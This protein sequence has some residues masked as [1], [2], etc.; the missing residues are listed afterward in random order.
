[1]CVRVCVCVYM[2]K[3]F[4]IKYIILYNMCLFSYDNDCIILSRSLKCYSL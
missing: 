1:M 4:H 3:E 2:S